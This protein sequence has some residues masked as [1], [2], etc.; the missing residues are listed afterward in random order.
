MWNS[1]FAYS[2][3]ACLACHQQSFLTV[4]VFVGIIRGS[5]TLSQ[6]D[7]SNVLRI[8]GEL[9][10]ANGMLSDGQH[11]FHV[12]EFG[13]LGNYC[14]D[15]GGHYN[16]YGVG[17]VVVVVVV[18]VVAI[19]AATAGRHSPFVVIILGKLFQNNHGAPGDTNRHIGD[20]GNVISDNGFIRVDITDTVAL[21]RGGTSVHIHTLYVQKLRKLLMSPTMLLP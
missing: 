15:A 19:T 3:R 7:Y 20:L 1:T 4:V 17:F 11:G 21:I 9:I 14:D 8:T 10:D 2:F 16:P 6:Y 18:V 13:E 12:H 5:V